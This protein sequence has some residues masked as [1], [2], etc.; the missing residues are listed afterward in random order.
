[1]SR[2]TLSPIE[3]AHWESR[4][5]SHVD[6]KDGVSACPL[7]GK[8]VQL[9][10]VRYGRVE[11]LH[12]RPDGD[13]YKGLQRPLGLRLVR[14]GFLYVID[15][16]DVELH[17]YRLVDGRPAG[18]L[19]K[20]PR[21]TQDIRLEPGGSPD[22]VFPHDSLLH[23][24]WSPIQWTA[25]KCMHMLGSS[26]DR[27][28]FMQ[29]VHLAKADCQK[30]GPHL[31]VESQIRQQLAEIAEQ[32]AAHCFAPGIPEKEQQD[33]H[34]ED[35]PLF[36]EAHIGQ[37][38]QALNPLYENDH[39]Y[40][41]LEDSLGIIEDLADEQDRVVDW[42][43]DWR[44]AHDNELRY[45][46]ASYID[47]L[48]TVGE[49]TARQ[50]A[51]SDSTLF[52]KT[53]PDQRASIY[54]WVNA[55]NRWRWEKRTNHRATTY[56]FDEIPQEPI[57][58]RMAEQDMAL[59]RREMVESLGDARYNELKH[60][61]EALEDSSQGTLNGIG[62]GAR[63]IQDLVRHEDMQAYLHR[64]RAH[65]K[66]WQQRLEAITED[67][68]H[69]LSSSEYHRSTWYFDPENA[70]QLE[71]ALI[72][73]Q[74]CMRD[75]CRTDES[76]RKVGEFFHQ[77][78]FY[79]LPVFQGRL[80]FN[81]LKSKAGDLNKWLDDIRNF[82]Q[83]L[84]DANARVHEIDQIMSHHW[85]RSL[86][87]PPHLQARHQAVLASYLPSVALGM[88]NWLAR[89]HSVLDDN[90]LQG[91][92][93]KLSRATNRAHRLG[94]LVALKT[95]GIILKV[96][97]QPDVEQFRERL[98]RFGQLID[99]EDQLRKQVETLKKQH[100]RRGLSTD[101]KHQIAYTKQAASQDLLNTRHE[102]AAV[103]RL[104][105]SS[106]EPTTALSTGYI[107]VRL[108]ITDAQRAGLQ[109]ETRRLQAGLRGGYAT[110]GAY[111]AAFKSS[112]AP[113]LLGTLQAMNLGEAWRIWYK[114]R[115][116][117]TGSSRKNFLFF[118]AILGVLASGLTA[119]QL[120]HIA[121]LDK[122]MQA[123]LTT[124]ASAA[125]SLKAVRIGRLGLGLGGGIAALSAT[126]NIANLLNNY[127]KWRTALSQG[128]MGEQTGA[129]IGALGDSGAAGTSTLLFSKASKEL[130]DL[131]NE[132]RKADPALRKIVASQAWA[133]RGSHFLNF[134]ARLNI[135]GLSFF[136]LQMLGEAIHN[137]YHLDDLQRW[138]YGCLWGKQ[139]Q[140]WSDAD[141]R[142]KLAESTLRPTVIDHG[143]VMDV[144]TS[145]PI[146][147]L[148]LI[149][150]G[151]APDALES[152][153]L[154]WKITWTCLP[155]RL[156]VS[157]FFRHKLS[158][159]N[160][161]PMTLEL[162]LAPEYLGH[163]VHLDLCLAVKP[164]MAENFLKAD[165]GYLNYR[166]PLG[167]DVVNKPITAMGLAPDT[168][169]PLPAIQITKS[170][171]D[172]NQ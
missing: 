81:Y 9:I 73:E 71:Q 3:K 103:L 161:S 28:Y 35:P 6:V 1:M 95:E 166:I 163:Q 74:N 106:I 143:I 117:G 72:V 146:R 38:K 139:P 57:E 152:D 153:S 55:R 56:R 15:E 11:R 126:L 65:L 135:W 52:K 21:V 70:E 51:G 114:E 30:G 48:M 44:E 170:F 159:A 83:G 99:R 2:K 46:T 63:G 82:G 75:L 137:Y 19:W 84:V 49:H 132:V 69:L 142:Q 121:M 40:L 31:R 156:D 116:E 5:R 14:D 25:A 53:T 42:I 125:G 133:T 171:I 110:P 149:L 13:R 148:H 113:L 102:R 50:H 154:R 144:A 45:V 108:D 136:A 80:D 118:T 155:E 94:L 43:S 47:T 140:G 39:L 59:R 78:P 131:L 111:Q 96:A 66:R 88:N 165:N 41:V 20:G 4:A 10:P 85:S 93:D 101:E 37:L 29:Q 141:T 60:E 12:S 124:H 23:V 97:D 90:Q 129:L 89:M 36:R 67:R 119:Y 120:A 164:V 68:T 58:T 147:S 34:W 134:S 123:L 104:I 145:E 26:P 76:L 138:L 24:A 151:M 98:I 86:E 115:N 169:A 7:M 62:L 172:D 162:K 107:Q 17:E 27:Y 64:E 167:M 130:Y 127:E 32:P 122:S 77:N 16:N 91:H 158:L 61:I 157:D 33:Y 79:I 87:L 160:D 8:N 112:W 128:T 100:R 18:L 54:A 150:P 22:M 105:E 92:L 168:S 109:E